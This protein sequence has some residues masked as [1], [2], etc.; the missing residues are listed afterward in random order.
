[1]QRLVKYIIGSLIVFP[2]C[3]T[4]L[5]GQT[6]FLSPDTSF[7][8]LWHYVGLKPDPQIQGVRG[9]SAWLVKHYKQDSYYYQSRIAGQQGGLKR[10][11]DPQSESDYDIRAA[12]KRAL[13]EQSVFSGYFGYRKQ[14]LTEKKWVHNRLPYRGM[15]FLLADSSTGDFNLNGI[16]WGVSYS[17]AL[18]PDRFFWGATFFYNVDESHKTIFP[19]PINKHRDLMLRMS[20]GL[21]LTPQTSLGLSVAYYDC[22]SIMKTTRYS[23]EQNKTPT[24]FK[25]RGLDNPIIF[26]GETSEERR[27]DLQGLCLTFDGELHHRPLYRMEFRS[28]YEQAGAQNIDG[29]AYPVKQ[30]K[31]FSERIFYN[32]EIEQPVIPSLALCLFSQGQRSRQYANHPDF[33]VEIFRY[34]TRQLMGGLSIQWQ[35]SGW[36]QLS[37]GV[38]MVSNTLKRVDK[39]NGLLQY[40]ARDAWGGQ[41]NYAN[42]RAEI[43]DLQITLGGE[44]S[45]LR[46]ESLYVPS[47]GWYYHTISAGEADY[48]GTDVNHFWITTRLVWRYSLQT[49]FILQPRF[50]YITGKDGGNFANQSRQYFALIFSVETL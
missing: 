26:R 24:F 9:N 48:Y 18:V 16:H 5:W 39:F 35:L 23:M 33:K 25:I 42:S 27:L 11:Y 7:S 3:S 49:R 28:G 31:W 38:Y 41:L 19:K 46:D 40:F 43:F 6:V 1:M 10:P 29:G 14:V 50:G 30:G 21:R 22:Q 12:G 44:V 2:I 17:Q 32:A 15:P 34:D 8:P 4:L 36:G 37:P 20:S 13:N 47:T 45:G